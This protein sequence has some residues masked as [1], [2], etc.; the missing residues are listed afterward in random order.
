VTNAVAY[1][2]RATITVAKCFRVLAL[3][4]LTGSPLADRHLVDTFKAV[5]IKHAKQM[6]VDLIIEKNPYRPKLI[7]AKEASGPGNPL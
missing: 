1:Y 5:F 7:L 6:S 3:C 2:D 4:L